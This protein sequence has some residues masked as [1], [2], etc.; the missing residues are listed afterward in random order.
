[1]RAVC[2]ATAAGVALWAYGLEPALA[3]PASAPL[4]SAA[5]QLSG[6]ALLPVRHHG[7]RWYWRGRSQGWWRYAPLYALPPALATTE[8][9]APAYPSAIGPG[10]PQTAAPVL[11]YPPPTGS[12]QPP[13]ASSIPN[14][15]SKP[16]ASRP[17]IKWVN[18]DRA[19]R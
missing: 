18:P 12:T 15:T 8:V 14:S 10:Q 6:P 1:M 16:T 5:Q 19:A 7:H 11:A 17:S 9:P 3:L 13:A 2:I 4:T